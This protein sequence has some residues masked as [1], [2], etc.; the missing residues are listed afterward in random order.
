MNKRVWLLIMLLACLVWRGIGGAGAAAEEAPAWLRQA[1]SAAHPPQG[2][3]VKAIVLLDEGKRVVED[4]GKVIFTQLFAIKV[5][6]REGRH[7]AVAQTIF[8]TDSERVKEMRAWLIRPNGEVK[9]YGKDQMLETAIVD[10][11]IYNESRKRR[12]S[13]ADEADAGC[14]FGYEIVTEER[15]VFSQFSWFFQSDIPVVI[16]RLTLALP[17]GW[18]A[19]SLTF[20]HAKVEP[21]VSGATYTWEMRDLPLIEDEPASPNNL[22]A[23]LVINT[24]PPEGKTTPLRA[25]ASWQDVSRYLS[26]L[27]DPQC[28]YNEAM[29]ARARELAGPASNEFE[30][31][32]AIGRYAQ[33]VNYI[34]IQTGL[35]RG[36]GYRPHHAAEVFAKNYGDC[37][38]KANLMRAMLKA[39]K[40]EAYPVSIFSGDPHFVQRE[41]PSPQQFNHCIIAIKVGDEVK[42]PAILNH[43]TLGRLMIF[44]PTDPYTP[45]GDLPLDQQGSY[46]LLMA[47]E[48]GD[49]LRMPDSPPEA[50]LVERT[51]D[52]TLAANGSLSARIVETSAGPA[53][54]RERA[55]LR[56]AD[57]QDYRQMIERW[58]TQAASGIS[59]TRLQPADDDRTGRFTLEVEFESPAY[60]Q[61]MQNRLLVFKPAVVS[62]R[63]AVPIASESRKHPVVLNA[64]AFEETA[65]I[66]LPEGFVVD[67]YPEAIELNQPFGNYAMAC[68]AKDGYL[69]FRRSFSL[70]GMLVPTD[71]YA[72]LRGF[73]SRILGAEQAPVVLMRK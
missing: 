69:I 70:K 73:Y 55:R 71:Q 58:V 6:S 8:N 46:A 15:S 64:Q 66:K 32:R 12:I 51:I 7:K 59:V 2:K 30:R 42:S 14:V 22:A 67:E 39:L 40:I 4:D 53:A 13:A 43:P 17:P 21:V 57:Q 9:R 52:A 56:R 29:E 24:Y 62:R 28:Y 47:G 44:D 36:G 16:S 41:W 54:V 38:D 23:R 5:L 60:A 34:S 20:N 63:V 27:N 68:E 48:K 45:V 25:F 26:E 61:T 10:N 65:R 3:E 1:A 11:D 33:S 19:E 18:R 35:G 50:N 31:I 72:A 49:L 37:K